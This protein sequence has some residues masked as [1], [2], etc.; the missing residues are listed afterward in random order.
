V[1]GQGTEILKSVSKDLLVAS[2]V[3]MVRGLRETYEASHKARSSEASTSPGEMS[4]TLSTFEEHSAAPPQPKVASEP[5]SRV[6][7]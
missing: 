4:S 3:L 2:A 6:E 5:R 7:S 1:V